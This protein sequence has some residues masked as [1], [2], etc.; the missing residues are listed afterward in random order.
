MTN[1]E[2]VVSTGDS[3]EIITFFTFFTDRTRFFV[4]DTEE[5]AVS[6]GKLANLY[7]EYE[8]NIDTTA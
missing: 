5:E 2:E 7:T 4:W 8:T 1:Y 3:S 6:L